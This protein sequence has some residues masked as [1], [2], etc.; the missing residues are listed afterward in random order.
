MRT[1]SPL[2]LLVTFALSFVACLGAD[3][4]VGRSLGLGA[5]CGASGDCAAGLECEVEHGVASCRPH[6]G[7]ADGGAGDA[8]TTSPRVLACRVATDCAA[9]LECEVEH[10]IGVCHAHGGGRT[11]D[12][13]AASSDTGATGGVGLSHR[14]RLRRG[15]R[16]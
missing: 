6:G 5:A 12:G 7:D 10:G 11:A 4:S 14:R 1:L 9:G 3:D 2:P 16:V 13:G 15:P 8:A